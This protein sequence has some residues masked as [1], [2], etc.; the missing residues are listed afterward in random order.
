MVKR[1]IYSYKIL[2][3]YWKERNDAFYTLARLSVTLAKKHYHTVLY[4]DKATEAA[5]KRKGIEFDE[6]VYL[7]SLRQVN[8]N[9][10]GLAKILAMQ[11]QT[12]PYIIIDLDTLLFEPIFSN[13]SITYGYKEA[14]PSKEWGAKY[15]KE[16]YLD[17]YQNFKEDIEVE[18]DWTTFPSNSLVMVQNPYIVADAYA[19]ILKLIGKDYQR[20]TVQ[21]YEQMLLYA[22]LKDEKVDI[23]FIYENPPVTEQQGLYKVNQA[24]SQKFAHFDYYYRQP[25]CEILVRE[26][27]KIFVK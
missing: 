4:C 16:Y 5:F 14:D 8:E 22:Y 26:L 23:G 21:F 9:N 18:L 13:H 1:V 27:T 2:D 17:P 25:S 24:L 15:I 12:E 3:K 19:K 6:I 7:T 10:Y 20:S 11:E